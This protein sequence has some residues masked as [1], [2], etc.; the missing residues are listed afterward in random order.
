MNDRKSIRF[1]VNP[2]SGY[3]N[4][5]DMLSMIKAHLDHKKFEFSYVETQARGHGK[6]LSKQAVE[7]GIDIIVASGGD[8]TVNEVAGPVAHSN[9]SLAILPNGSGNGFA[10]HVGMGRNSIKA[11]RKIN[12]CESLTVDTCTVNGEF[13]LN[14]A[15]IGFDGLVAYKADNSTSRGLQM[16]ATMVT[17]ELVK[18]KA[19]HYKIKLDD[20]EITGDYTVVAV[21]NA[22]MYGYNFNIAPLAK[23]TDGLL[24]VVFIKKAPLLRIIGSSWRMLNKTLH[25][26]PLVDIKKSKSVVVSMDKP[27]YYHV[28]GES[29]TFNDP[30]HF[31]V[32]PASLKVLLPPKNIATL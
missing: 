20:E 18:F 22:A 31:K 12:E 17:Q 8:G 3:K 30:L 32:V 14:L 4:H 10:M 23:L 9:S 21:A 26:S 13:F 15:G 27:Y 1:I 28:D 16:Y 2:V 11:I 25:K 19:E 24:D 7:D 29:K 6:E 5:E